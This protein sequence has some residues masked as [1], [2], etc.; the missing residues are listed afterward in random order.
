MRLPGYPKTAT[1]NHD[2]WWGTH[3]GALS[4]V[5]ALTFGPFGLELHEGIS[6]DMRKDCTLMYCKC[7]YCVGETLLHLRPKAFTHD[8]AVDSTWL[9]VC[10]GS[11]VITF[12]LVFLYLWVYVSLPLRNRNVKIWISGCLADGEVDAARLDGPP[13]PGMDWEP[14]QDYYA[15]SAEEPTSCTAGRGYRG[16]GRMVKNGENIEGFESNKILQ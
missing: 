6:E 12:M 11:F 7:S 2:A 13:L 14:G 5:M 10:R 3:G 16:T 9:P 4:T 8:C 1:R 15:R